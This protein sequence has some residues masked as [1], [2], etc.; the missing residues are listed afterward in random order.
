MTIKIVVAV[1]G[2]KDSQAC[3]QL[4]LENY[5]N[6]E[7]IG[8]FNDTGWEHP[9]TYNHIIFMQNYYNI[10]II[11]TNKST[12]EKEIIKA[13][14][15]PNAFS[16]FCTDRLKIV[17]SKIF[18]YE[19][20]KKQKSGFEVWLGMRSDE[21]VKRR[22]RYIGKVGTETYAPHE[23]NKSYPKYLHKL[24]ILFRLPILEWSSIDVLK[25]LNG[26]ENKLYSNGF[27]R[28]GCFPCLASREQEHT[29]AFNYD[30]FGV[31]QKNRI[32]IL[33]LKIHKKHVPANTNQMCMFCQ[34]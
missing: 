16:R 13:K 11:R 18:Y 23:I 6:N 34:I 26:K 30:A 12:V 10:E 22:I 17:P 9:E 25:Y 28:V 27:N 8:L 33:E 29:N 3:L 4:A 21:S 1:S 2:G 14:M 7:I 20:A 15:F 31:Q 19:L 5:K 32:E 24:G